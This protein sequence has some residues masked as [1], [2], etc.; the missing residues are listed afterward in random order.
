MLLRRRLL[1]LFV[2]IIAGVLAL[3]GIT[4]VLIRDRDNSQERE[5]RLSVSLERVA[6]LGTAYTDQETGERGYAL[7]GE[8]TSLEPFTG[9]AAR[10][11]ELTR[12]LRGDLDTSGLRSQL[13]TVVAAA[14]NLFTWEKPSNISRSQLTRAPKERRASELV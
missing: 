6:R 2:A 3:G 11:A 7:T 1:L 10:A 8:T 4:A 12:D 14:A 13:D 5:R 9:G